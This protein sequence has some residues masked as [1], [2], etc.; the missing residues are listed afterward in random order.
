MPFLVHAQKGYVQTATIKGRSNAIDTIV[1]KKTELSFGKVFPNNYKREESVVQIL[2]PYRVSEMINPTNRS[3]PLYRAR[4]KNADET[5]NTAKS[6]IAKRMKASKTIRE[7]L[8]Q[9]NIFNETDLNAVKFIYLPMY[10]LTANIADFKNGEN[11]AKYYT[12]GLGGF[13]YLMLRDNKL[14][15]Y[16]D[17]YVESDQKTAFFL[18]RPR[19]VEIVD[20][21][22]K[23]GKTPVGFGRTIST[24]IKYVG[25][26]NGYML[27][28]VEQGHIV[29]VYYQES[30]VQ[31]SGF[32]SNV[33]PDPR[34]YKFYTTETAESF[35]SGSDNRS[36]INSWLDAT[37]DNLKKY[38]KRH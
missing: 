2:R 5:L 8:S 34:F 38:P 7:R 4:M 16:L 21:L 3:H 12:L 18:A 31:Q 22:L 35:F 25:A 14:I 33:S 30:I 23:L 32:D 37:V 24:E 17:Y 6:D 13:K 27:G 15:G 9:V 36:T 20:Q 28:Y 19:E 10:A 29:F 11:I 1:K 26:G